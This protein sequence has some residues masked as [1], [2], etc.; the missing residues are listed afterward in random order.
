MI[1]L[2]L[3][4]PL[5]LVIAVGFNIQE[6]EA[7]FPEATD[8]QLKLELDKRVYYYGD[9]L[10]VTLTNLTDKTSATV[11]TINPHGNVIYNQVWTFDKGDVI[12]NHL[13]VTDKWA[14]GEWWITATTTS[15][16]VYHEHFFVI[17][18]DLYADGD[19]N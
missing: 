11:K 3:L 18:K 17:E 19:H 14:Q 2:L 10:M 13:Y 5:L 15:G 1:K 4:L 9:P 8:E 7:S 16:N 12:N 6:S